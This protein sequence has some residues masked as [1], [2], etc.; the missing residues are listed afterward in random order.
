MANTSARD[1]ETLSD[2]QKRD[3]S[4]AALRSMQREYAD[5]V[6]QAYG[7]SERDGRTPS[8]ERADVKKSPLSDAEILQ[9]L[10]D[11]RDSMI[12]IVRLRDTVKA[13][14]G[15]IRRFVRPD[16]GYCTSCGGHW[17]YRADGRWVY[18][19]GEH[20]PNCHAGQFYSRDAR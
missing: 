12:E 10:D 19:D 15:I 3:A 8:D 17:L 14:R 7:A 6:R 1:G 5:A 4:D 2:E 16:N 11:W 20:A 18:E 13:A 9:L